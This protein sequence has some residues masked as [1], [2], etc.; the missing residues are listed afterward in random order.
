MGEAAPNL[1]VHAA[2]PARRN[3]LENAKSA[4]ATPVASGEKVDRDRHVASTPCEGDH[5]FV[6]PQWN[7]QPKPPTE[8]T[9]QDVQ[10]NARGLRKACHAA[11][12]AGWTKSRTA[13][14]R[15][16]LRSLLRQ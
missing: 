1:S 15:Y 3:A 7:S 10:E 9:V 4:P 2:R 12:G 11:P 14:H 16:V 6:G 5:L 8:R 13:R